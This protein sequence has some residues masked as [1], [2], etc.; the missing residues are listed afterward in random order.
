MPTDALPLTVSPGG[1]EKDHSLQTSDLS[2]SDA[3]EASSPTPPSPPKRKCRTIHRGWQFSFVIFLVGCASSGV[4][5]GLGLSA[6]KADQSQRF[7]KIAGDLLS[8]FE[9]AF[10][11][12]QLGAL[13]LHQAE[14]RQMSHEE[15]R[16]IYEYMNQSGIVLEAIGVVRNV[17][18]DEREALENQTRAFLETKFPAIFPLLGYQGFYELKYDTETFQP[19]RERRSEQPFYFPVRLVEPLE[20]PVILGSLD[21]DFYSLPPHRTAIDDAITG[22][23]PAMTAPY[24]LD[25][26]EVSMADSFVVILFHPGV[27]LSRFPHGP[28]RDLS[29]FTVPLKALIERAYLPIRKQD[30]VN[31]F[32]FDS[33]SGEE[34]PPF[35]GGGKLNTL[36]EA[37]VLGPVSFAK[38]VR[39]AS[40]SSYKEQ[41]QINI[42][43][44]AS[45]EWTVVVVGDDGAFKPDIFF[46]ILAAAMIFVA[47][48]CLALWLYTDVGR[49]EKMNEMQAAARAEKAAINVAN[50]K[51]AH[52]I[53]RELNDYIAHE[54]C[55]KP[56]E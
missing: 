1:G 51:K 9:R 43:S 31:L 8:S 37:N 48:C 35:I 50:A 11:D 22:G 55:Q 32:V 25:A 7:E 14:N 18:H 47:C 49:R 54:V 33:T 38:D 12:Y 26:G 56:S 29:F 34:D 36:A 10:E 24:K 30:Q 52:R 5:L 2:S 17:T 16:D 21:L 53:E 3:G 44:L 40:V 15:F 28:A 19:T 4:I 39:L 41:K 23:Q 45:R 13:W 42:L 27:K 6:A 46:I 20:I